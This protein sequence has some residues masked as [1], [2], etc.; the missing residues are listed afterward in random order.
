LDICATT[1]LQTVLFKCNG[2]HRYGHFPN[3]C[4]KWSPLPLK[5]KK[6]SFKKSPSHQTG[7]KR[8]SQISSQP[9]NE[10]KAGASQHQIYALVSGSNPDGQSPAIV[11]TQ[12]SS[13]SS[14]PRGKRVYHVQKGKER[15]KPATKEVLQNE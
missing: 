12:N 3:N 9:R 7:K 4:L 2:Y 11:P 6:K 14:N 13:C 10:M 5:R 15:K 1:R 8:Q